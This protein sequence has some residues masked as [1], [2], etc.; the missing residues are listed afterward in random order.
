[1]ATPEDH[2]AASEIAD[3]VGRT[4]VTAR[5]N[6][7]SKDYS[8]GQIGAAGD[9]LAHHELMEAIKQ[10]FPD[11]LVLSEEASAG[12]RAGPERLTAP[13]LWIIDPIDGTREYRE[14]RTD[15]AVHVALIEE[16]TPTAAA[17][18]LPDLGLVFGTS[19]PPTVPPAA[20]PRR[21]VVSRTRPAPE[22]YMLADALGATLIPMGSAGAKAMAVVRGEADVYV[23]SGGQ[24]EW[25][26]AAPVGVATAAGLWCSRIDGTPLTYNRLDTY[27][28]DLLICHRDDAERILE[29]IN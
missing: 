4:L 27:L 22:A 7:S 8:I 11:D 15:W 26:S 5:N 21:L 18:A 9:R 23:H 24:F 20:Q 2:L 29:V 14:G 19:T 1:M 6:M 10:R 17:V 16:G 25:D 13:R 28:P 12:E 3:V